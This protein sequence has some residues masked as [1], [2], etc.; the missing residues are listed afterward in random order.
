MRSDGTGVAL[1][2]RDLQD[3]VAQLLQPYFS[4]HPGLDAQARAALYLGSPPAPVTLTIDS[5]LEASAASSSPSLVA[6][7]GVS[8]TTSPERNVEVAPPTEAQLQQRWGFP[9]PASAIKRPENAAVER[10]KSIRLRPAILNSKMTFFLVAIYLP[11]TG[12]ILVTAGALER[13][14][15][16]PLVTGVII[17]SFALPLLWLCLRRPHITSREIS[18][19]Q[20]FKRA[21]IPISAVSGVGAVWHGG[22]GVGWNPAVWVDDGRMLSLPESSVTCSQMM[23]VGKTVFDIWQRVR[24]QQG[25]GGVLDTQRAE[26]TA[27]VPEGSIWVQV[28]SPEE[29]LVRQATKS[30]LLRRR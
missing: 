10:A 12:L 28:W 22:R 2:H 30:S 16:D 8:A 3:G 7:T 20:G 1:S 21:H 5:R 17:C 24:Q 15:T 13:N 27:V 4:K 26:R 29:D 18:I 6:P 19:P 14:G 11:A 25:D 23:G 9:L